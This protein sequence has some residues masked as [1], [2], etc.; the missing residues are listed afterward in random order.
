IF[1]SLG[2]ED[3]HQV[4]LKRH[5]KLCGSRVTLAAGAATELVVYPPRFMTFG[6]EHKKSAYTFYEFIFSFYY[7][8]A[9]QLDVDSAACHVGSYGHCSPAAR[10]CDYFS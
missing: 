1:Y 3:T 5:I 9:A 8:V 4:V 2:T 10:L 7:R 6:G